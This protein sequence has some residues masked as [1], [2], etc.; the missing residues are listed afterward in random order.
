MLERTVEYYRLI[1]RPGEPEDSVVFRAAVLATVLIS[2]V[3]A[4]KYGAVDTVTGS[5]V[6]A[7][8]IAGS[9]FSHFTRNRSNLVV[10][11][12]LSVLLLAVFA[13][14]WAD[15]GASIHDLRYPL[16]R[17]FLWLQVLHSFDLPTRRDLDFSLVSA[18]VLVA[19]A[20]SLSIDSGFLYLLAPFFAAGLV[21]LYLGHRSAL[22]SSADVFVPSGRRPAS[23]VA[24][25]VVVLV[26][27]SV[28]LFM[29]LPRLPGFNSYYLPMSRSGGT[30]TTFG[31]LVRNPGYEAVTEFPS[32]P[33]PYNRDA[34]FG[35]SSFLDLRMRGVPDDRVVMKVR[36][37]RPRYWRAAAFDKFRGNGWENSEKTRE[38]LASNNLPLTMSYPGEVSRY[39]TRELVQT[40]FIERKLPNTVFA[41]YVLR[42]LYFPTTVVKVDSM[43]SVLVPVTLDPG[44]IYTVVSEVSE[45]TPAMLDYS[46]GR[47]PGSMTERYCQLPEMSPAVGEL[48]ARVTEGRHTVYGKVRAIRDYLRDTYPYDLRVG[49]QG[50][51]ENTVEFFLFKAKRGYCEHFA[52]A[53]AVLCRTLGIP[54]RVAV[55]YDA[56]E[57][58]SLTGYYEVNARDAH[59][60]TEVYLPP[61]GWIQF[62]PTPGWG[63]PNGM[64]GR[65]SVWSGLSLLRNIGR[66]IE[67]VF[68]ASWGRALKSVGQATG[69]ALGAVVS[70]A[71][72]F[73][74]RAWPWLA[75]ALLLAAG[76]PLLWRLA[77]RRARSPSRAGPSEPGPAERAARAFETMAR[78]LAT[79]GITRPPAATAV[80][81]GRKADAAL[82][83]GAAGRAAV[84][85]NAARFAPSVDP[86]TMDELDRAVGA[87]VE[88]VAR[89]KKPRAPS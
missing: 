74:R 57:Y 75:G 18:A 76:V 78:A 35:F 16:V 87:V 25:A 45:V 26:P 56:G 86:A 60:W 52:T 53:M 2:V 55:G 67:K 41:A 63:D 23:A 21:S 68:P 44:L 32:E 19:F 17:L 88:E 73:A 64:P 33:L 59:A 49:R 66:A 12:V 28:G 84:L 42:D 85:F 30:P 80:E 65:D 5:L 22:R 70:E 51:D 6:V 72:S 24:L 20:G 34:Y 39:S 38:E 69:R 77:R 7:G 71:S 3:A 54:A 61:Y 79:L 11:L 31:P 10:K 82:S 43:M 48:A 8:V 37:E 15:L 58:N 46:Y 36:S 13:V 1:N 40:F 14:F 89:R 81:F 27:I 83:S 29:F 62:D 47:Y 9:A 4:V 50:R